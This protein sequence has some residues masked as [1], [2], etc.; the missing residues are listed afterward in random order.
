MFRRVD[1]KDTKY[2]A[3]NNKQEPSS[4]QKMNNNASAEAMLNVYKMSASEP[5]HILPVL[6]FSFN[7]PGSDSVR[8]SS[9]IR[10]RSIEIL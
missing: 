6:R 9:F 7:P 4:K 5:V 8:P 2:T 3:R 10:S 1:E